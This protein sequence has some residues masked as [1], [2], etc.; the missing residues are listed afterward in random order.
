PRRLAPPDARAGPGPIGP[1]P[2]AFPPGR[3]TPYSCSCS[4]RT[5]SLAATSTPCPTRRGNLAA[6]A[7]AYW[8]SCTCSCTCTC[9]TRKVSLAAKAL[10]I[11][12][13]PQQRHPPDRGHAGEAAVVLVQ[14]VLHA[15]LDRRAPERQAVA[16]QE[17]DERVGLHAVFYL[18]PGLANALGADINPGA[19]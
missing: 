12:L 16:Q 14:H 4:T 5:G 9:S 7:T 17:V 1:A 15:E 2:P 13:Q 6:K 19:H 10:Q 8:C 3:R 11:V 18:V